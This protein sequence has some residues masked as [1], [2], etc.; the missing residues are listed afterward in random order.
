MIV[1]KKGAV[2]Q[3]LLD[4]Q[5][6]A[7]ERNLSSYDAYKLLNH[8]EK[9]QILKSLMIE[10]GHICAYCMRKIP[11]EREL[12][13]DIDKVTIE[14]WLPRR[15]ADNTE[16]GQGLDYNNMFAVCSGNRGRRNTRKTS[17]YTCDAKRSKNHPQ[18]TLNPCEPE[19]IAKIK[20]KEDGEIYSEDKKIN[21]DLNICLNLNCTSS[22][23]D[24]P[25]T[26]KA[27]LD[28]LQSCIPTESITDAVSYCQSILKLYQSEADPKTPYVGILLWWL[29]D[30]IDHAGNND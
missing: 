19:T 24:L 22:G 20:Y 7:T 28:A 25:K 4:T 8:S 10:Q 5:K 13:P 14:H 30:F 18:L 29:Q 26:R 2:P 17:D 3:I 15:P 9:E 21:Y 12:P 11:D 23:V 1:I 16:R 6:I 27:V